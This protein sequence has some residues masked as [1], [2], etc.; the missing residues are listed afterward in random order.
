M[1]LVIRGLERLGLASDVVDSRHR[2]QQHPTRL[3]YVG[4]ADP[5]VLVG[6]LKDVRVLRCAKN[7]GRTPAG[8]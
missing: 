5:R 8:M 2:R 4:P 1:Y 6:G 7:P 3:T